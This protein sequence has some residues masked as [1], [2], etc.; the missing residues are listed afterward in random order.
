M[1]HTYEV[2]CFGSEENNLGSDILSRSRVGLP[3]FAP[4]GVVREPPEIIPR[5]PYQD[6]IKVGVGV[7][8]WEVSRRF[9]LL[10]PTKYQVLRSICLFSCLV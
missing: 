5:T 1:Y 10:F 8:L 4:G 6:Y 7:D 9:I 2:R 3:L